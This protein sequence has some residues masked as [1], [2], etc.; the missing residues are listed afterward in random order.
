MNSALLSQVL[1]SLAFVVAVARLGGF[2]LKRVGQ[3]AVVGEILAGILLGPSLLGLLAPRLAH[4][5]LPAEVKPYLTLLAQLGLVIFMLIVG[6]EVE[7]ATV[8]RRAPTVGAVA[9][10]AAVLPFL[11]GILFAL[12]TW[13]WYA[14]QVS[15]V[16]FLL[17]IGVAVAVTAFPVLAR[18][19]RDR[20]LATTPMGSLALSCAAV[21]DVAAWLLLAG[22]IA[23]AGKTDRSPWLM[24]ILATAFVLVMLLVVR[25][26]LR[27]LQRRGTFAKMSPQAVL[28]AVL[29]A[30]VL[31][32][33]FTEKIG[34]HT[35]FGPFMVGLCLPRVPSVVDMVID[36]A[37]DVSSGLLL[38]AFF[39]VAGTQ[40]DVRALRARDLGVLAVVVVLSMSGK[41]FGAAGPARLT[42]LSLRDSLTLGVL[43]STRG[44]TELVVL[45]VGA[46]AGLLTPTLYTILVINAVVTTL[47]TGPLL[48]LI[49]RSGARAARPVADQRPVSVTASRR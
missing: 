34:L 2:L 3:P 41:I 17:Y 15:R 48:T 4:L 10:G 5:L 11:L 16:A 12:V 8:G 24:L 35:I 18:I 31:A 32:A 22:V 47:A 13:R 14:V 37:A 27:A 44:L 42:G 25:P 30:S 1:L 7:L 49:E 26:G 28:I 43:L 45:A 40:V 38:P 23:L 9:F 19:L 20:G 21:I 29:V 6:I 36:R 33:C 46:A 39:V